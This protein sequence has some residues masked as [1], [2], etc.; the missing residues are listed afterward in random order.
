MI[1]IV[2]SF[3]IKK[4]DQEHIISFFGKIDEASRTIVLN[5]EV[6]STGS[7]L[8]DIADIGGRIF[9]L[10]VTSTIAQ[11][12]VVYGCYFSQQTLNYTL[13]SMGTLT[14]CFESLIRQESPNEQYN[15]MSF[16][17][18]GIEKIFPLVSF[19][20][21]ASGYDGPL[22][23]TRPAIPENHYHVNEDISGSVVSAFDGIPY[24]P[25]TEVH[26]SQKK[27]IRISF[28]SKKTA[29]ELLIVLSK[30]KQ[31]IE[32]L[33]SREIHF[34]NISFSSKGDTG[35]HLADVIIAPILIPK[36]L[37]KA[38]EDNPFRYSEEVFFS[39][40]HGWLEYYEKYSR[41]IAIWGKTVY[42]TS[43]SQED[44]FIWRCQAFELLCTL[45]DEIKFDAYNNLAPN[46]ANPN[47]RNY[48]T[49]VSSKYNIVKP[50][51][52]F[53]A[54]VKD[55]RDKMTHN[56]PRKNVTEGQIKN[57]YGLINHFLTAT[58]AELMKFKCQ[59]PAF[60]LTPKK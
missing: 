42:N 54:D 34:S 24:N 31:Y 9:A 58:I 11:S 41:V 46:Q 4:G 40:M 10:P 32:F 57:A 36:T 56:N 55:V 48:L 7:I 14:G 44:V 8:L 60:F 12:Y 15:S 39:G 45:T 3:A 2:T 25:C 51:E 47:L 38:L 35:Y 22:S 27:Y 23:I 16:S 28:A 17:F 18:E 50:F 49:V 1:D 59:L 37:T 43:V 6:D 21:D 52:E 30:I 13:S 33:C 19:E 29:S 5:Y 20:I 26:I 53:F